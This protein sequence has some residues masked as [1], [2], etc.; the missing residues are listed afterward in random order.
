MQLSF[1]L[2]NN[3]RL[4]DKPSRFYRWEIELFSAVCFIVIFAQLQTSK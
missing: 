4:P 2:E 3:G 1:E